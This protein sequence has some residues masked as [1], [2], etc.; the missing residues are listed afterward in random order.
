MPLDANAIVT[1][2]EVKAELGIVGTD[3]DARLETLINAASDRIERFTGQWWRRR[4][5]TFTLN[6]GATP[7]LDVGQRIISLSHVRLGGRLLSEPQDYEQVGNTGW[8][9]R[10]AGWAD[11]VP[12]RTAG[13]QNV[14]VMGDVGWDPIPDDVK[15][16]CI[17]LVGYYRRQDP[18]AADL[19]SES[20]GAYAYTRSSA[21][22]PGTTADPFTQIEGMLQDYVRRGV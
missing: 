6:G 22:V 2:E 10:L 18:A 8:L 13:I 16:A 4:L 19:I 21:R 20:I 3:E 1:L 14:E 5:A 12:G 7:L 11:P 15:R 17:L 9:F